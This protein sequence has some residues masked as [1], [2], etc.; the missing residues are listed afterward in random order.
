M[1][2]ERIIEL[3]YRAQRARDL[4]SGLANKQVM[5][6]LNSYAMELEAEASKLEASTLPPAA[7]DIPT[8]EPSTGP[9]AIVAIK[10]APDPDSD[11]SEG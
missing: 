7:I 1:A 5:A 9:E 8:K 11:K 6:N 2:T 3:R 10:P 4:A